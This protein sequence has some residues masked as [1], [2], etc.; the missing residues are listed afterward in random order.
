[1]RLTFLSAFFPP[2]I[3]GAGI[4]VYYNSLWLA[5]MGIKVQVII[6][7]YSS[8]VTENRWIER[9]VTE[10]VDVVEL[11]TKPFA[12]TAIGLMP[13]RSSQQLIDSAVSSFKP[14][15]LLVSDPYFLFIVSG[16]LIKTARYRKMGCAPIAVCHGD[17]LEVMKRIKMR[18]RWI[19]AFVIRQI[20][21][22]YK[23]SIFPSEY[24]STRYSYVHDRRI[25]RFLGVD[26]RRF[27]YIKRQG[28][29]RTTILYV[30]RLSPDKRVEFMM[31]GIQ[32]VLQANSK[33]H[34]V[35]VGDGPELH[36]WQEAKIDRVTVSGPLY[37]DALVDAY[38]SAD[39]FINACDYES[40]GLTVAE[41]MATGLPPV[42]PD[43][44]AAS[45][46]FVNKQ[47]GRVFKANDVDSLSA[48]LL[49]LVED[50]TLR[51]RLG[52]NASSLPLDWEESTKHLLT[53]CNSFIIKAMRVSHE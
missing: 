15:V 37:D 49:E 19:A 22:Q 24:L 10:G 42:V 28:G 29:E 41:A 13:L 23:S 9:L 21:A 25:V 6:P 47:S 43:R 18:G 44:G 52:D 50:K 11:P 46:Q 51:Q 20:L 34:F 39:I 2:E 48:T 17:M 32:K 5:R 36:K 4:S 30:G 38:Q 35:L 3:S 40:F 31:S 14:D 45:S 8:K 33:V 16:I 53:A 27:Q 1:M 7:Q 26:R 12:A